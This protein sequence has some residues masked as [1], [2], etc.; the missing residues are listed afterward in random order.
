[1][2][3]AKERRPLDRVD[4]HT[5]ICGSKCND[6][7]TALQHY[8]AN[9]GPIGFLY[10]LARACLC[11]SACSGSLFMITGLNPGLFPEVPVT[12]CH[13]HRFRYAGATTYDARGLFRPQILSQRKMGPPLTSTQV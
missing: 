6:A 7:D 4:P 3:A 12:N 8:S 9:P 10:S 1:M 13:A 2:D 5:R 11:S